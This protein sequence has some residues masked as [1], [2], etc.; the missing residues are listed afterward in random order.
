MAKYAITLS[1][2]FNAAYDFDGAESQLNQELQELLND[3]RFQ[4]IFL[5][6]KVE[7]AGAIKTVKNWEMN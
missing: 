3:I 2:N 1:V 6:G 4:N 7:A 5:G